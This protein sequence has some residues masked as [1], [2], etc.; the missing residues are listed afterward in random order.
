MLLY[1]FTS[2]ICGFVSANMFRKMGGRGWVWNIV[3]AGSLFAVPFFLVW[4]LVN[5][6]AWYH[7]STQVGS[8]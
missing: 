8:H 6:V 5:S 3:L 4:S 2:G 1:A 7:Q